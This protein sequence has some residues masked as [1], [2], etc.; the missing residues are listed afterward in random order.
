MPGQDMNKKFEFEIE[1]FEKIEISNWLN[2][3]LNLKDILKWTETEAIFCL[4]YLIKDEEIDKSVFK[5]NYEDLKKELI[6]L[7][8]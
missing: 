6:K 3:F 5:E 8:I 2:E 7:N 4:Q 1:I